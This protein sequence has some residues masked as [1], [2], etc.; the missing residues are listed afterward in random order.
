MTV[1]AIQR[2][3]NL[4]ME[5]IA[6]ALPLLE[7]PDP[8]SRSRDCEGRRIIRL[9]P[10]RSWG[11]RIVNFTKYRE[12]V[13]IEMSRL[14]EAARKKAYRAKY[15][16]KSLSHTL[17][18][19]SCTESDTDADMSHPSPGHVRDII[20][21]EFARIPSSVKEVIDFGKVMN[22]PRSEADCR[23]FYDH[24]E[25]QARTDP[26]GVKFW[27][28]SNDTV[29]TNWQAKLR[30]WKGNNHG[31]H[32]SNDGQSSGRNKGTYNEGTSSQYSAAVVRGTAKVPDPKRS[33]SGTDA[34]AD[35]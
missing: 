11:W 30:T 31:N 24:Y 7:S 27:I 25:A 2:R 3:T 13:T 8:D 5:I 4:P 22:P 23:F 26:N 18:K 15:G 29:I 1:D 12:S 33:S 20:P 9:D 35:R 32:K 19:E 17:S 16:K 28:T 34:S 14:S 10:E 21:R 6:H